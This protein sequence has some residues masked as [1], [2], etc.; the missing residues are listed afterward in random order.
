LD[1]ETVKE[2]LGRKRATATLNEAKTGERVR[3][4]GGERSKDNR[5]NLRLQ[6][7]LG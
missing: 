5:I 2:F 1:R 6:G 3:K 4:Q 7:F